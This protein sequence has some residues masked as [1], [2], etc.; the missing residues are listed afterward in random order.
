MHK[1]IVV[2]AAGVFYV[3]LGR[4]SWSW[5]KH[6]VLGWVFPLLNLSGVAL[7]FYSPLRLKNPAPMFFLF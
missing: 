5:A 6:R 3:A 2:M 1:W 7:L 4:V